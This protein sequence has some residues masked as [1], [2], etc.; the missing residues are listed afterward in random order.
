MGYSP[1]RIFYSIL[2][3]IILNVLQTF[4]F[5]RGYHGELEDKDELKLYYVLAIIVSIIY[6]FCSFIGWIGVNGWIRGF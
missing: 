5:Y 6:I 2:F 3:L 1:L 4:I